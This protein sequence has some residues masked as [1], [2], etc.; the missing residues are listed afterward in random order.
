MDT[1]RPSYLFCTDLPK[2]ASLTTHKRPE[3]TDMCGQD[4]SSLFDVSVDVV[5]S[6]FDSSDLFGLFI[7]D[8]AL[9]FFFERHH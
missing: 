7:G 3:A 8:L 4:R 5:N 6:L 1:K 2:T 9:E